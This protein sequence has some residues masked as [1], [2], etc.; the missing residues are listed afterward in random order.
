MIIN[1]IIKGLVNVYESHRDPQTAKALA[2]YMR[3]QYPRT[4]LRIM[5]TWRTYLRSLKDSRWKTFRRRLKD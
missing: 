5:K 1:E 4:R 3:D 2:A